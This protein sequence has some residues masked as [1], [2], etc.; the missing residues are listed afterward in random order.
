MCRYVLN[1]FKVNISSL[2]DVKLD[3]FTIERPTYCEGKQTFMDVIYDYVTVG[4]FKEKL[5]FIE[6]VI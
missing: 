3:S 2:S 6:L 5:L 4:R 1:R